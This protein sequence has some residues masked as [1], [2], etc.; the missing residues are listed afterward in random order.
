MSHYD[1]N[2][3]PAV[4]YP[5]PATAYPSGP[6]VASPP[7][8]YPMKDGQGYPQNAPLPVETKSR[9]D[10]FWKGWKSKNV[11]RESPDLPTKNLPTRGTSITPIFVAHPISYMG[12]GSRGQATS[13]AMP[14]VTDVPLYKL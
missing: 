1:Q 3:V 7:A 10:G 8:G 11:V 9:G 13:C 4:A 6:Y 5:P 2:Q 12:N 14:K